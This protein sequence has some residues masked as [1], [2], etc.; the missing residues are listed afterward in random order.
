MLD[1][2]LSDVYRMEYPCQVVRR[3]LLLGTETDNMDSVSGQGP[4]C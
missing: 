4:T 3:I 1:A 2:D